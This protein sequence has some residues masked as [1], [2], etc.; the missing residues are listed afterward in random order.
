ME[1]L[2]QTSSGLLVPRDFDTKMDRSRIGLVSG[3]R[4]ITQS[5]IESKYRQFSQFLQ[6]VKVPW[7]YPCI[8]LISYTFATAE[9]EIMDGDNAVEDENDELLQ[10]LERPNPVQ[11]GFHFK[12]LFSFYMELL[13]EAFIS[14]EDRDG[15]GRPRELY[16]LNPANMVVVPDAVNYVKG[17]LFQ[18]QG[19]NIGQGIPYDPDEI[20]HVKLPNPTN[21]YRGLGPVEASSIILDIVE[22]MSQHELSYYKSGGRI[23]GV[24]ETEQEVS[25]ED[26]ER[27]KRDWKAFSADDQHR[28]KTAILQNG[29][30]Y[31]PISE[32]MRSLN[33]TDINK[34]KRDAIL[35]IWGVPKSKLGIL[36]DAQY[37]LN[38]ADQTFQSETMAPKL[39]RWEHDVQ[40]LVDL[41]HPEWRWE[42]E[43]RNWEDDT[44]KLA[45]A[46]VMST[47]YAYTIDD[48]RTYTGL[49]PLDAGNGDVILIPN[50]LQPFNPEDLADLADLTMQQLEQPPDMMGA[51]G[52]GAAAPPGQGQPTAGGTD[53]TADDGQDQEPDKGNTGKELALLNDEER[54]VI[55]AGLRVKQQVAQR[56]AIKRARNS[57]TKTASPM[58]RLQ[59]RDTKKVTSVPAGS[60]AR[61]VVVKRQVDSFISSAERL[62][63]PIVKKY[64]RGQHRRA[65]RHLGDLLDAAKQGKD[66]SADLRQLVSAPERLREALAP[67][68]VSGLQTGYFVGSRLLSVDQRRVQSAKQAN[69]R[70]DSQA[71]GKAT[72]L[73]PDS[74][75]WRVGLDDFLKVNPGLADEFKKLGS[76]ANRIDQ[77]STEKLSEVIQ[78]GLRRG[79]SQQQISN[80]VLDE[81]YG[82]LL[83]LGDDWED[84]RP[85]FISRTEGRDAFVSGLLQSYLDGDVPRVQALDGT[86]YDFACAD[87]NGQTFTIDDAFN[88]GEH[89]NGRL[90]FL[91]LE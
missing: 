36:E 27:I 48:I 51:P 50:N 83:S 89:P 76:Q 4:V 55:E 21:P 80:G 38:D 87:R 75:E 53:T 90:V 9:Y 5:L 70:K 68:H 66:L 17:Y 61:A 11:S 25:D 67:V 72:I 15:Y 63:T 39:V 30:K 57:H 42:F 19:W 7:V 35:T 13:G 18:P 10:L 23:V 28:L 73:P 49:P 33:L 54:A 8:K 40:D 37:K 88:E 22:A 44:T 65:V 6:A 41:F 64:L 34:E 62:A 20:I 86:E 58:A 71:E 12:E 3:G 78:E 81:G 77:T 74:S 1:S 59:T 31:T 56:L 84:W 24:L 16:L 79:Y 45:N 26:F 52:A 2:V 43:R 14:L 69:R 91:P 32:G 47:A 82:G 60:P 46:K 29:L 85:E